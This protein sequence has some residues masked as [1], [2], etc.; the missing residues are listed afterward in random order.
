MIAKDKELFNDV[1]RLE[2]DPSKIEEG[3]HSTFPIVLI[4]FLDKNSLI[5]DKSNFMSESILD[6]F[7]GENQDEE[8]NVTIRE[9]F[10]ESIYN[11][12]R[13][14]TF[15]QSKAEKELVDLR[16]VQD[17]QGHSCQIWVW[18][19]SENYQYIATGCNNGYLRIW[20]ILGME[21][22]EDPFTLLD[23]K[24]YAEMPPSRTENWAI[25]DCSWCLR[26]PN[27]IVTAHFDKK[28]V[29]WDIDNPNSALK[30][31]KHD[32]AVTWVQFHPDSDDVE[33]I[34]V[35]GGIDK[36]YQVWNKREDK[37]VWSQQAKQPITAISI[38]P[39]GV[40]VV[41]G[42][43][44][45]KIIVCAYDNQKLNYITTIDCKNRMG[46]YSKGTKVTSIEFLDNT[47]VFV[48]TNDSRMRIVNVEGQY[49]A[50]DIKQIKFK[51]HVNDSL[52]IRATIS[53]DQEYI[54]WGSED[55]YVYVWRKPLGTEEIE[56]HSRNDSFEKFSPFSPDDIIPTTAQFC[57]LEIFRIFNNK[58]MMFG[59]QRMLK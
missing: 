46:K 53:E 7:L 12:I 43:D 34:F 50:K 33:C 54:L 47:D 36:T 22:D 23:T 21:Y 9:K 5:G 40:R 14:Q 26:V 55:G 1:S 10:D 16:M 20:K 19:I 45:G 13:M 51:G 6:D 37:S 56:K 57:S 27:L 44:L 48:T 52:P 59:I 18:K 29:L 3:T 2:I 35:T 39:D 28:A 38:S 49:F 11:N 4:Y 25:L 15:T 30:E 32:D 42:L 58:Y 24:T 41:I 8:S 31:F 17:F